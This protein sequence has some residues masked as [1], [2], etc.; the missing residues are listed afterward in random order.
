MP[1][2]KI[3]GWTICHHGC[4]CCPRRES[5]P[6]N[7][8][9]ISHTRFVVDLVIRGGNF[10]FICAAA[11]PERERERAEFI[12]N[13]YLDPGREGGRFIKPPLGKCIDDGCCYRS[14]NN[15]I[16]GVTQVR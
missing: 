13:R 1:E 14:P 11:A 10:S 5:F 12:C 6:G 3:S 15:C 9:G 2:R 4:C 7:E 16:Q 8:R